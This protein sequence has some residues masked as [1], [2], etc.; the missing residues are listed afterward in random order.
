MSVFVFPGQGSQFKGMGHDLYQSNEEVKKLFEEADDLLKFSLSKIM[1]EGDEEALKQTKVTQPA[2]FLHSIA[3]LMVYESKNNKPLAVAGHSLGEFSSLVANKTIS[4]KDGLILVS[5]RAKAMQKACD[6]SS[7]TMAA[8]LGLEDKL[9]RET[10]QEFDGNVIAA[11]FNCPGQV[12]ISGEINA[13][14]NICEV[15]NSLGA[16]RSLILP[17]SGAFHSS[18]MNEAKNELTEA[19]NN[20]S[21]NT[22][23]CPVYQNVDA[24]KT[25]N[26]Q[27]IK[28]NLINQLT[29]PVLWTQ[30]IYNMINDGLTEFVEIG[31]GK[32][33]QGLIRKINREVSTQGALG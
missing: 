9:V 23:I 10:C 28:K 11:N 26:V 18:L 22:P 15:F 27:T 29:A 3:E 2:I 12:V 17:V 20:T 32:V 13:I 30:T 1:F 33:L 25:D 24:A 31:P 19:I 8:I 4:F 5:L 7:G 21:F 16:R 6:N 14:K